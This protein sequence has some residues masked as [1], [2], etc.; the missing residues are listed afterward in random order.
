MRRNT[1]AVYELG[2]QRKTYKTTPETKENPLC[3][4][5]THKQKKTHQEL[6]VKHSHIQKINKILNNHRNV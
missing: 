6:K 4:C 5:K 3:A 1:N 2:K